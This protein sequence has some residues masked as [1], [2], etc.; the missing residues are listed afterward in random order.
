[1]LAALPAAVRD[2]LQRAYDEARERP[3]DAAAAG[4][5]AMALHAHDQ[6]ELAR[7]YYESASQL[8]PGNMSWAYLAG[9][10]QAELGATTE[11]IVS[12]RRSLALAPDYIPARIRLAAALLADGDLRA[13][14]A[15]YEALI[16]RYPELAVAHYGLGRVLATAGDREGAVAHYARAVERAP[17]FGRAHYALALEHRNAGASERAEH[18]LN[19]HRR[20]GPR[21]PPLPDPVLDR[22]R[23]MAGTARE[24]IVQGTARAAEGR[25]DEAITLHLKALDADPAATQAHVNLISL[26][27]RSGRADLAEAHYQAVLRQQSNLAEAHYNYGVLQ[28]AT[29][30]SGEAAISFSHALAADPFHPR[31]HNNVGALLARQGRYEEAAGHFQQALAT[32]PQYE[33]A[34]FGLG[35]AL[36]VLKRPREAASHLEKLTFTDTVDGPRYRFA[37]ARALFAAGERSEAGRQAEQAMRDARRAGASALAA[38]IERALSHMRAAGR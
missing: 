20:W 9:V 11:A 36:L 35:Q 19:A 17:E 27:G 30:R 3:R 29:G 38:E 34:R 10:A 5:L 25:L 32:D 31:A 22:V 21:V 2:N 16:E 6:Y 26:Y 14:R 23:S 4:G 15:E 28:A 37:L 8:A 33:A 13:S 12:F 7:A 1:M 18:H 24:L